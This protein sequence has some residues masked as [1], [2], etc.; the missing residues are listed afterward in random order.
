L[1]AFVAADKRHPLAARMARGLVGL[2]RN[3][4]WRSTQENGWA[5]LALRDYRAAQESSTKE[6][7]AR[8]FLG[9]DMV[10]SRVFKGQ[11]DTELTA[12]VPA[13]KV[14]SAGGSQVAFQLVG[15]GQLFYAAELKYA[16]T[17]LPKVARDEGLFVK[18][19]VRAVKPEEIKDAVEWIPKTSLDQAPAGSLVLIDLLLESAE[20]RRQVVID[21]P[22]PAG[23]EP[24]D[25]AL[26]TASKS[27]T[28]EDDEDKPA[29]KDNAKKPPRP[30]ELTGI[31]AAF[32]SA[33]A[34]REMHDD[35]VLTFVENL[36][37]GM[38]HFR[39]LARATSIGRFVV[40]PTRV[41]AMY[42]PEVWGSTAAGTFEVR[43]K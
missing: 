20:P 33:H 1:R 10:G 4:A 26:D 5:L 6:V 31:G 19:L 2:R 17:V 36:P 30:G 11:A 43:P 15:D 12:V 25:A 27:R 8:A 29:P 3:G 35:R 18:K 13:A 32:R 9:R 41:E 28:V 22:L 16:T 38:Y 24:I 42:S 7:E 14:V 21:D 34:H 37:P 40:P 23:V 39:Y